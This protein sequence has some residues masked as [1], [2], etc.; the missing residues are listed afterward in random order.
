[1]FTR[2]ASSHIRVG[3]F[4]YFA[5]R[6][7]AEALAQLTDHVI[8]RHYPHIDN[9]AE[10]KYLQMFKAIC[11][12]QAELIAQWMNIGFIHGVMNT[13]NM[14]ASGETIDYGP[15]AF[16]DAFH[17]ETVFSSIDRNGRYAYNNQPAIG[18]WNLA[19]L[20]E[21][22]LPLFPGDE[23]QSVEQATAV[24]Q[25]YS[26]WYQDAWLA[27]FNRKLG[28]SAVADGDK[29]RAESLLDLLQQGGLDFTLFFRCLY[30][31]I[32]EDADRSCITEP[33]SYPEVRKTAALEQDI[34]SWLDR[35]QADLS[36][37][38]NDLSVAQTLM[39]AANPAI[40]P[41]NHNVQAAISAAEEGDFSVFEQLL[42][43]LQQPYEDIAEFASFR[44]PPPP[45]QQVLRT[46]C[47]T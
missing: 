38:E 28:F 16:M 7:D 20:A 31:L 30:G 45:Q 42:Q 12:R 40:I 15:C 10:D 41:R 14:T 37:R 25:S 9:S 11:L 35:W 39:K 3:T 47:G 5:L 22:L 43:A 17:R 19:R 46:F 4:Q 26:Q 2:V 29:E 32:S 6:R 13:D 18:Q 23:K 44:T 24:L 21:T 34:H 8:E 1:V 33:L 27:G 36:V